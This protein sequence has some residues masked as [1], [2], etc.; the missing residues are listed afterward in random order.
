MP[1]TIIEIAWRIFGENEYKDKG[2]VDQLV[3]IDRG[4]LGWYD[5]ML[6]RLNCSADRGG[7]LHNL[8]SA[9]IV[10]QDL[11]A[12]T[13]GRVEE[14]TKAGM[15][16]LSQKVFEMFRRAYIDKGL[17]FYKAVDDVPSESFLGDTGKNLSVDDDFGYPEI[18]ST[19]T[20]IKSFVIYQLSNSN[21]P[22]GSGVG[23]GFY[24]TDGE[25]D[26]RKIADLMNDYIFGFCFN[27]EISQDNIY[28]FLDHCMSN[29]S[30]SLFVDVDYAT[31]SASEAGI[32]SG[33]SPDAIARYWAKYRALIVDKI[34]QDDGRLVYTSNYTTSYKENLESVFGILD[35]LTIRQQQS[36]N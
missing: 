33:F 4:V 3:A 6:F 26:S 30:R 1:E 28:Y 27:P 13:S 9:L 31:F 25:H 14:L 8:Q 36:I 12:A 20:A 24:H 19:R 18:L 22:T 15:K 17:N 23:C 21:S 32:I 16:M 7:Q 34:K 5:L 35:E 11:K 2:I 10:H 29:L